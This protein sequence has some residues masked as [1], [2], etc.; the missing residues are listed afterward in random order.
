MAE[1]LERKLAR[2]KAKLDEL[3]R[4]LPVDEIPL[5]TLLEIETLEREIGYLSAE[6]SLNDFNDDTLH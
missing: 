4:Q 6:I 2:L 1:H 3:Q 5:S